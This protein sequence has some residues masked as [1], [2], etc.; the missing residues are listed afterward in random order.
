MSWVYKAELFGV[1]QTSDG[2]P[3]PRGIKI[4]KTFVGDSGEE[5]VTTDSTPEEAAQ[6]GGEEFLLDYIELAR[7]NFTEYLNHLLNYEN[8][9]RE[10]AAST[11][12]G[13]FSY[14]LRDVVVA[15]NL[16]TETN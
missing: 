11:M 1:E 5:L 15:I 10:P 9:V 3:C 13:D 8:G 7:T 2:I 4:V 6:N 14:Y 12:V 16:M